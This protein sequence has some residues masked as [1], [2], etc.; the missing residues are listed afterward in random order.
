MSVN[1]KNVWPTVEVLYRALGAP[2]EPTDLKFAL[3]AMMTECRRRG[4]RFPKI[5]YMRWKQLQR[6]EWVPLPEGV[7]EQLDTPEKLDTP[8]AN[9]PSKVRFQQ[10]ARK[11]G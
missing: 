2:Q 7:F 1:D 8:E 3:D 9:P 4:L 11:T 6:G 5:V 10:K